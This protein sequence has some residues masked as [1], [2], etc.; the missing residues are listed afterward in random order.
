MVRGFKFKNKIKKSPFMEFFCFIFFNC[1]FA[2]DS[3]PPLRIANKMAMRLSRKGRVIRPKALRDLAK[4][5]GCKPHKWGE[6][7]R[8]INFL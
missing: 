3:D 5:R 2:F 8:W 7:I 4:C 6:G 1:F